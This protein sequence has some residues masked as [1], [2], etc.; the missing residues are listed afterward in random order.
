M[1]DLRRLCVDAGF[2]RVETFIASG[3]VVFESRYEPAHVKSGLE[4][5]LLAH[6]GRPVGVIVRTASEMTEI[7]KANPF[8]D[9]DPK[10]TYVVFLNELAAADALARASGRSGETMLLGKREIF[11][12]YPDGMGQSKLRIPAAKTGTARKMSTVA[13]LAELAAKP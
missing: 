3:N 11:V 5:Q 2:A 12:H 9:T 1:A 7:V 13:K 10:R 4:A 8:P 6:Y